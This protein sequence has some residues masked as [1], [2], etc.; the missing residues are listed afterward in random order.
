METLCKLHRTPSIKVGSIN[1]LRK[2]YKTGLEEGLEGG[3]ST[4]TDCPKVTRLEAIPTPAFW[5]E[6]RFC[7]PSLERQSCV[8]NNPGLPGACLSLH[9]S[10]QNGNLLFC[11]C[12]IIII[13]CCV[14]D[15]WTDVGTLTPWRACEGLRV[16]WGQKAGSLLPLWIWGLDSVIRLV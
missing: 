11:Y 16:G 5:A 8:R 2:A 3:V 13:V 6:N 7:I 10:V 4:H 1:R 15:E 9:E 12:F 14:C